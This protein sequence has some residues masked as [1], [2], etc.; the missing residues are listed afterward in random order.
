M[1]LELKINQK[2]TIRGP[3]KDQNC[4]KID[5]KLT[6]NGLEIDQKWN[7]NEQ[8]I[9]LTELKWTKMQAKK[10][11]IGPKMSRKLYSIAINKK[12]RH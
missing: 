8:N 6:Q 9:D 7:K 4:P 11:K 1:Y 12:I 5:L 10:W 3:K 2:L